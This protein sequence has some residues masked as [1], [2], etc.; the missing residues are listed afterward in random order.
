MSV[1]MGLKM[2]ME[3]LQRMLKECGRRRERTSPFFTIGSGFLPHVTEF[4][5]D[6]VEAWGENAHG[7]MAV[8]SILESRPATQIMTRTYW[9]CW[10][11]TRKQTT[12]LS[13]PF[14]I[15]VPSSFGIGAVIF[16]ISSSGGKYGFLAHPC[17]T[18]PAC[19]AREP[20]TTKAGRRA[21]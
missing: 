1:S 11:P 14:T 17:V 7:T 3:L 4:F 2:N 12:C 9:L 19:M 10:A 18:S 8:V 6:D 16:R 13:P 21:T 15:L 20:R 5:G